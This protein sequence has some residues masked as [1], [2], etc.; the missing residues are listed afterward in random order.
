MSELTHFDEAGRARMVDVGSK[1]I[2][3]RAAASMKVSRIAKP[4]SP[5]PV[6]ARTV[7]RES[8]D[9]RGKASLVMLSSG[10]GEH[11]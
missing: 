2:T 10:G 1:A 9:P 7:G 11:T 8:G 5:P 3:D 6:V 4:S